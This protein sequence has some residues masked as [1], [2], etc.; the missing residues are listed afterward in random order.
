MIEWGETILWVIPRDEVPGPRPAYRATAFHDEGESGQVPSPATSGGDVTGSGVDEPLL[1]IAL[2]PVGPALTDAI[3]PDVEGTVERQASDEEPDARI[4]RIL[5]EEF[6]ARADA[7]FAGDDPAA[8][9]AL[10]LPGLLDGPSAAACRDSVDTTLAL[11][12]GI[13]LTEVPAAP[14]VQGPSLAYQAVADLRYPTGTVT[15][16]P[17]LTVGPL[18]RLY[19]VLPACI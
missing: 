8:V 5:V 13:T 16:G 11:A 17:V 18:G 3:P 1:A 15:F 12:E 2:D 9:D 6:A 4:A 14:V 19:L 7:A 10:L